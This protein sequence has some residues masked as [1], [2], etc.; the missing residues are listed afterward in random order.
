MINFCFY[1]VNTRIGARKPVY[2]VEA[3]A[4]ELQLAVAIQG[5]QRF[6]KLILVGSFEGMNLKP[7]KITEPKL[8]TRF[9]CSMSRN[10]T[11]CLICVASNRSLFIFEIARVQ[12]RHKRLKEISCPYIV[13]S[14]NF[15][16]DGDW[17]CVGSSN[18][19]AMFS[20]WTDGP[21]QV[22]LRGDLIDIDSS[23]AFFQHSPSEAHCAVQLGDDEFL[24]AFENCGV[25][26]NSNRKKTRPD[27]LM[28][29]AKLISGTAVS[30]SYPYLYVFTEAGLV[31]FNAITSCWV[32]TLSSCRVQPLS[33]DA[34]LCLAHLS[35]S[36]I[37]NSSSRK[38]A[39]GGI[40]DSSTGNVA[41]PSPPYISPSDL[42]SGQQ[43]QQLV[44]LIHLPQISDNKEMSKQQVSALRSRRLQ[45]PQSS[46]FGVTG[47]VRVSLVKSS[48]Q[49]KS[50][51]FNLYSLV[52]DS[53][54]ST[55]HG[56]SPERLRNFR[57]QSQ[58]RTPQPSVQSNVP[59]NPTSGTS[60]ISHLISGPS[61]FRHI[62]HMGPQ[63]T[64]APLLD[65]TS[66][67]G[68]PPLTE[69]ERIARF[70]SV[71][72]EKCGNGNRRGS[73]PNNIPN[74]SLHLPFSDPNNAPDGFHHNASLTQ[75]STI[76]K[77]QSVD[78]TYPPNWLKHRT[79]TFRPLNFVTNT[80]PLR[81][82]SEWDFPDSVFMHVVM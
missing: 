6:L 79:L 77:S 70:K 61:D 64:G 32:S 12:G 3:L 8:C 17:I 38:S 45:M 37:S 65:L 75:M 74:V 68:E 9:T 58:S 48:I 67:P 49:Q 1:V 13:Q 26:M 76:T 81:G 19:F 72:E 63:I 50:S 7:I 25:Y 78:P 30:F 33:M 15:V 21:A 16:R 53:L 46:I 42:V 27:N 35:S 10:N 14:I 52:E 43:Q 5:K 23:L 29:P 44:R 39:V 82:G 71:L 34:H 31:V 57:S 22:L 40:M 11:V 73:S 56:V 24:L 59:L 18:Y 51:R 55:T 62:S 66:S 20:I 54:S 2:Q 41:T 36:S 60:R 69:A 80:P 47:R 28:W 4:E